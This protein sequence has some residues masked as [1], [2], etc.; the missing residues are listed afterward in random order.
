MALQLF[1]N[2][3]CGMLIAEILPAGFLLPANFAMMSGYGC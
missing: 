1:K 3:L 2:S